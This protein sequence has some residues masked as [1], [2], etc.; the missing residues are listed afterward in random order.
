[1]NDAQPD[2]S[3]DGM[4]DAELR[5]ALGR[6]ARV[7]RL[8]IGC[9][10]DGTLAPLVDDPSTAGPLPEAVAAVRA[11]A[12]LGSRDNVARSLSAR[13]EI[14]ATTVWGSDASARTAATASGRGPAVD[15]SSTRGA[16]VPS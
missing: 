11:L 2:P 9:D 5:A 15:G 13:P 8:L 12:S 4:L 3:P 6:I 7:P 14:T 1:M 10:Y 16:S